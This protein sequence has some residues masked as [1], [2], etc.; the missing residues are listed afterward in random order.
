M[1]RSLHL[2]VAALLAVSSYGAYAVPTLQIDIDGATYVG[3][4]EQSVVTTDPVFTLHT[5]LTEDVDTT[6]ADTFYL[7]IAV[8]PSLAQS[9]PS[10]DLGTIFVNGNTY[11]VT[12]DMN[13]GTPPLDVTLTNKDLPPHGIYET[14]YLELMFQFDPLD[15]TGT[16]NVQDNPGG[17]QSG[18]GSFF[19]TFNFDISGLAAGYDLHFDL[20]NTAMK[21]GDLVLG[22]FAPFSHDA[23]TM[24]G[25]PEP[26]IL[27]LMGMGLLGLGFARSNPFKAR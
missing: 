24:V 11:N 10:P 19:S 3:G 22:E 8:I 17:L 15:Q 2:F 27:V 16:Y 14:Y 5:L 12:G 23:R 1:Y 4:T 20:Y 13:Y 25:V 26:G 7:S 9:N 21:K 6:I 18:T